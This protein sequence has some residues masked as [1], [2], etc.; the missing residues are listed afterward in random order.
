[1]LE[2]SADPRLALEAIHGPGLFIRSGARILSATSRFS[3]VSR[4]R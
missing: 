1:M 3:R 2:L 4:A